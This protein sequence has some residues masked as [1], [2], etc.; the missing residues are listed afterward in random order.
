MGKKIFKITS[1]ANNELKWY[2][3][4]R[5]NQFIVWGSYFVYSFLDKQDAIE[6]GVKIDGLTFNPLS[7]YCKQFSETNI[8]SGDLIT[9]TEKNNGIKYRVQYAMP[10]KHVSNNHLNNIY[11]GTDAKKTIVVREDYLP[12]DVENHYVNVSNYNL[13]V[14]VQ[15]KVYDNRWAYVLP[16]N[17][18]AEI[19]RMLRFD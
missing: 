2:D 13:P 18:W 17:S 5:K 10:L 6:S 1:K 4:T 8:E 11:K 3:D 16:I 9:I 7:K 15:D 14:I 12:K 19:E